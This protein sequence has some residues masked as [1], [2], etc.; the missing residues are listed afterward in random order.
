MKARWKKMGEEAY[1]TAEFFKFINI[2]RNH[3]KF[4]FS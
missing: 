2:A 4:L 1:K 3:N